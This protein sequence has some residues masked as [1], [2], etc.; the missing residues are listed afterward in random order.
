MAFTCFDVFDTVLTRTVGSPSSVFLLLGRLLVRRNMIDISAEGFARARISAEYRAY[1]NHGIAHTTLFHIYN[2]LANSIGLH[3]DL[4]SEI[5]QLE[6]ELERRLLQGV[7]ANRVLVAAARAKGEAIAFLSDMYLSSEFL[8]DQLL[9]H[10]FWQYGDKLY[11]SCE[12]GEDKL[13]G[14]LFREFLRREN[15]FT[16]DVSFHRGNSA[17]ADILPA[18]QTGL[19]VRP[20]LQ[21]NLNRYE[22][23]LEQHTWRT[24]GLSSFFAGASRLARLNLEG[25]DDGKNVQ[26][27]VSVGVMGPVLTGFLLWVFR[28]AKENNLKRLYFVSR[29]GEILLRMAQR[30]LQKLPLQLDLRYFYA[31]R[32][33][34][35]LAGMRCEDPKLWSWIWDPTDVFSVESLLA[36]VALKPTDVADLLKEAGFSSRNW[37]SNLSS[38]EREKLRSLFYHPDVK[39]LIYHRAVNQELVVTKYLQ[40]EG[41]LDDDSWAFVDLGWAASMQNALSVVLSNKGKHSPLGFYMGLI[42]HPE[43]PFFGK[44]EAYLF[45]ADQRIGFFREAREG[46]VPLLEAFCAAT[47]GTVIDLKINNDKVEPVLREQNNRP[48]LEW[49]LSTIQDAACRFVDC[50]DLDLEL[51]NPFA[52][53]RL[54]SVE[55]LTAFWSHP[56]RKEV[57]VWGSFPWEDGVGKESYVN[58]LVERLTWKR[59][60][61]YWLNGTDIYHHRAAWRSGCVAA[62]SWPLRTMV[63]F[64]VP[65][66]ERLKDPRQKLLTLCWEKV[67]HFE[68]RGWSVV[69]LPFRIVA[70]LIKIQILRRIVECFRRQTAATRCA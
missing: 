59:A 16:N 46:W 28:K 61:R 31:S 4:S 40:Q 52:D 18:R 67:E 42:E 49:G 41:M 51:V 58:P 48:C 55:L 65:A 63:R 47:H 37:Q 44:R 45:D 7:E 15:L 53:M 10:G 50:L 27:C 38:V 35:N 24:E 43:E 22:R 62:S 21:G 3:K 54:P 13:T 25:E 57:R 60:W 8:R 11:V 23:I 34:L 68:R 17:N 70:F 29:E 36:R 26:R 9:T 32:Q 19:R 2:E 20:F 56:T 12:I 69:G 30:L 5:L 14:G 66:V 64:I 33:V 1:K 6:R 39:R